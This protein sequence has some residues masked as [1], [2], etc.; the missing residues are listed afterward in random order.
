MQTHNA[1]HLSFGGAG[2]GQ[3]KRRDASPDISST[4]FKPRVV[5]LSIVA[6]VLRKW[7]MTTFCIFYTFGHKF[8][9]VRTPSPPVI[10]NNLYHKHNQR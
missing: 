10:A 1:R 8:Q 2:T 5:V 9:M 7:R 6:N 4:A 3:L